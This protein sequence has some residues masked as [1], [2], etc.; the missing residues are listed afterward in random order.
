MHGNI[1]L[2][3]SLAQYYLPS[4]V[5]QQQDRFRE[6]CLCHRYPNTYPGKG[7]QLIGEAFLL[8]KFVESKGE[9]GF[10]TIPEKLNVC[11]KKKRKTSNDLSS[12]VT[13]FN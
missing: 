3:K 12:D 10:F 1:V 8:V 6:Y 7:K 13:F 5:G 9:R 2:G 11:N 4:T